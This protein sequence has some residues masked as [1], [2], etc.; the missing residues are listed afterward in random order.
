MF[1]IIGTWKMLV[2]LLVEFRPPAT[3]SQSLE[4]LMEQIIFELLEGRWV[5]PTRPF[6]WEGAVLEK[7]LGDLSAEV[8]AELRH[9]CIQLLM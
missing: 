1:Q 3:R 9:L 8:G 7:T 6:E 5:Q 2:D 4:K